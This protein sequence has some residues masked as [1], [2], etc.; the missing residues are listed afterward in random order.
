MGSA[1]LEDPGVEEFM[2]FDL[3]ALS[4]DEAYLNVVSEHD[5]DLYLYALNGDCYGCP[6]QPEL[7]VTAGGSNNMTLSTHHPW[8]FLLTNYTGPYIRPDEVNEGCKVQGASLGEF[9][10]YQLNLTEAGNCTFSTLKDP[11]FEYGAFVIAVA[12]YAGLGL[13]IAAATVARRWYSNKYSARKDDGSQ[14]EL[15]MTSSTLSTS[16]PAKAAVNK[17]PARIRVKSLDTFRGMSIVLMIFVNYGAGN[18]WFL[19]HSTWNGLQVADLVFPW[20]MWIMGVCIPMGLRS[21]LKRKTPKYKIFLRILKRAI[22]LFILGIILNS[23]GGWIYLDKYRIPGVLQRFAITY[24]VT[25]GIALAFT[26]EQPPQYQSDVGIIMSDVIQ[27]LP[28]WAVHLLIVMAHTLITFLLPV[29]DCPTGYLGPG[30]VAL[31]DNGTALPQCVGGA[32]GE[33]D[34]WLLTSAHLYQNPTA[35]VIYGSAAFD[36]EGVLGSMTSIFQVFL[37]L[38]AGMVLQAHKSHR[39]RVLRWLVW[40]VVLGALG[41]GLSG[42]SMND[43]VIPLN[44]NLW[45]LSYVFVTSCFAYFLLASC[46]LLV[47]VWGFWSG[48]PFFQAG[49]NSIFLYCGHNVAYNLFP[50][51]YIVGNMNTHL[52]LLT[53]CLWGTTLWVLMAFYM[54]H[55]K[56]FYAV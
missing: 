17:P 9:G 29:P 13:L 16:E 18:Y 51:H 4:V 36:P 6:L 1:F 50:W 47:D 11:V 3:T 56:Q 20:F 27:I 5:T 40:S 24:L 55:K 42:A 21:A 39:G 43:G 22:K 34:R 31:M 41:A 48:A 25:A 52:A 54:Y 35:K 12:V 37:G 26:P 46:Y 44:K 7:Y 14:V 2:G 23:L 19:E 28:Q 15:Q 10:V 45:S 53:E 8:T 38:Q 30:G 49:M 33:V 32:A